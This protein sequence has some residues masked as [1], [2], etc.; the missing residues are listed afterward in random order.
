MNIDFFKKKLYNHIMREFFV[1]EVKNK[2]RLSNY[3]FYKFPNMAK[4]NIYIAFRNK[5][6]K[7]NENDKI[8]VYIKDSILFNIPQKIECIYEDENLYVVYKPQGIL[9]NNETDMAK[10][11]TLDD[12]IK[13]NYPNY[14]L[15][16]RLDRNTAGL[17][18]FAKN[19]NAYNNI[20]N[21]FKA[22]SITKEYIAYVSG[23]KFKN[24]SET[25]N[26]YIFIDNKNGF[27]KIY[28]D[29]NDN[30]KNLKNITTE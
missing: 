20:L 5:D 7:V 28:N 18:I 15:C 29:N 14:I 6:I 4:S 26:Q 21:G 19:L 25:L 10:E 17:V 23:Y 27:S 16:H 11:Q 12:L 30:I 2:T 9:S 3:I 13:N 8:Q 1:K 22:D 24:I